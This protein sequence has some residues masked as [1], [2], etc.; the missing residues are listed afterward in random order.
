MATEEPLLTIPRFLYLWG[1]CMF[2]VTLYIAFLCDEDLRT[3]REGDEDEKKEEEQPEFTVGMTFL[4]FKDI[5]S[6][7]HV[8]QLFLFRMITLGAM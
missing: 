8:Q 1:T 2:L 4:V 6:Q 5:L 3:K 7:K